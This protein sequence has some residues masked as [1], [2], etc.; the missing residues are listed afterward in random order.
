MKSC[1]PTTRASDTVVLLPYHNHQRQSRQ[2]QDVGFRW[3]LRGLFRGGFFFVAS[4]GLGE[5]LLQ[6]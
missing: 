2:R 4:A 5:R 6:S 1:S 3:S